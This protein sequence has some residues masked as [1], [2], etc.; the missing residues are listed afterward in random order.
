MKHWITF[1]WILSMVGCVSAS[2]VEETDP[3]LNA[4]ERPGATSNGWS[5]WNTYYYV[6]TDTS[7]R[8]WSHHNPLLIIL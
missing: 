7:N 5:L 3:Q 4:K 8:F 2:F 6:S 1:V